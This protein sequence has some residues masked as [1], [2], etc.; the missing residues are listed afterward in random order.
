MYKSLDG[1]IPYNCAK[2]EK[3]KDYYS[4]KIAI[5][6]NDCNVRLKI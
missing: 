1:N 6:K 5:K 3:R 2:K 4:K